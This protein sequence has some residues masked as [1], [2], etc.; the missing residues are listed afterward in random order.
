MCTRRFSPLAISNYLSP[1]PIVKRRK[2]A[3]S[4]LNVSA[5]FDIEVSSFYEH[6]IT[7]ET[8]HEIDGVIDPEQWEK[9]ACMYAWV[10]GINGKTFTGRTWKQF[11][12]L[13]DTLVSYYGLSC[14]GVILPVYVHNLSYEF[15]FIRHRFEW[16][17]VFAL[18]ERDAVKALT[19]DGIEFRCSWVLAGYSLEKVGEHL[20]TYKVEKKVGDLD[21]DLMRHSRTPLTAKEWGYIVNDALVVMAY[22]QELLDERKYIT[23]IPLT[24]T[25]FVREAVRKSCFW[26]NS[27]HQKDKSGKYGR[28]R[29]IMERLTLDP[30]EYL[31]LNEAFHGGMVHANALNANKIQKDV[32]SFDFC[33]SYPSVMVAE[34]FPMSKGEKYVPK[35]K[36]DFFKTIKLYLC[37][38]EVEFSDVYPIV[39]CDHIISISKCSTITDFVSDNGRVVTAKSMRLC[40]TS[41]DFETYSHF[42]AWKEMKIYQMYRYRAQYLPTDFVRAILDFYKT[43]TELKGVEGKEAELMHNK[44]N[45]NSAY[46][47]CVTAIC[48]PEIKYIDG[49]WKTETPDLAKS[50]DT[51]N[52]KKSRFLSYAWGVFVTAYALR[53]LASGILECGKTGD[54]C[55][56]DTDSVKTMH[57]ERHRDYFDAYN[58]E[59]GKKM[60]QACDFHGLPYDM[61][62]PLTIEGKKKP[63]GVWEYEG[64]ADRAIFLGAKRYATE[65]NGTPTITIAGVNKKIA[66]P[67]LMEKAKREGCDFF[68]FIKFD[69]TFSVDECGKLLHTY[70]DEPKNGVLCDYRGISGRYSEES[71]IHLCPTTYQMNADPDYLDYLFSPYNVED[72]KI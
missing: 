21:Y 70:V 56:A 58:E 23:R 24:K 6:I 39:T 71:Y 30:Q 55:Y 64:T 46:G 40:M 51:Y 9:R 15:Q 48:R 7:H 37:V 44:E 18:N 34:K 62:E 45:L 8:R 16:S 11:R 26:G 32:A 49:E 42:Y 38:F 3:I 47:M 5:S 28:Y 1:F 10:F 52:A 29:R 65:K 61:V 19:M 60:R 12:Q 4:Y 36:E 25:G 35:D 22:I 63:L 59:V 72:I 33:S 69:Y 31:L 67:A 43:K 68:D 17:S 13:C 2:S 54:Y 14:D 20:H 50:I 41:V 57:P 53:N 27:T 66:V